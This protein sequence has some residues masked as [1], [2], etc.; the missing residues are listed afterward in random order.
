MAALLR[1]E[2]FAVRNRN[3]QATIVAV[4]RALIDRADYETMTSRPGWEALI[5]ATGTS[6]TTV[7][8][9][10]RLLIAWGVVGRVASGRQAKYAATG[11]DGERINEAAVYVLCTPSPLALVNKVGTPPALGGS[12]LIEKELTHTRARGK[13]S[14]TDVAPPRL[15]PTGAASGA[16][17]AQVAWRPE[18][19]W[20][21]HRTPKRRDQRVAA[22]SEIRYRSFP[23]RSM[24]PKDVASS[25][26][27]FFLAGWT[28]A[29]ILHALDWRPDGAQWP[30][31][32]A[33][34]TKDPWRMRG[35]LRHRLSAW[36]T[37]AGEPLRSRDQQESARIANLRR[38]QEA[39]RRRTLE[40]QA[41]RA[42]R[43][44]AG[45]SPA[46][47]TALA[48]IRAVFDANKRRRS[49]RYHSA[50]Q[51]SRQ[52]PQDG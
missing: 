45:D 41:E 13:S 31:S 26:R 40:R 47:V 36:R 43:L 11:P 9:V 19:L 32:G 17:S 14:Q 52:S 20:P 5:E 29:D 24:T 25:C 44:D 7:A 49:A 34:D 22:A 8:R 37:E 46:K 27:D 33:P 2:N 21:A 38:E 10:L 4:L 16:P 42:A 48:Q 1:H 6:R 30:H 35:W 18:L 12:H 51:S 23:L 28:V 15:I 50:E 39:E 3:G